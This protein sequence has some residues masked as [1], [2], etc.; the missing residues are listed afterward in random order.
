MCLYHILPIKPK[1]APHDFYPKPGSP[2]PLPF[3]Q[4]Q[5]YPVIL[6]TKFSKI[7]V[8]LN[9]SFSSHNLHTY[10]YFMCPHSSL[11]PY[12]YH[13]FMGPTFFSS[14]NPYPY[15]LLHGFTTFSSSLNPYPYHDFIGSQPTPVLLIL[16]H[17]IY[18]MGS[19]PSPVLLI[20]IHIFT[21]WV[22]NL[23]PFSSSSFTS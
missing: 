4:P 8:S 19:Q 22:H 9:Q 18:F 1:P 23:I 6:F 7:Q 14:L 13:Y 12:P 15:H 17:I 3:T 21:S 5:F 11:N 2:P 10:H 20:L 16:I